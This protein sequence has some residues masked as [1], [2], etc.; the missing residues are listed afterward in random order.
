MGK[1]VEFPGRRRAPAD[2][3]DAAGNIRVAPGR[4]LT[5]GQ[6]SVTPDQAAIGAG[7]GW[8][9]EADSGHD[10][11]VVITRPPPRTLRGALD[12]TGVSRDP[13]YPEVV[14]VTLTRPLTDAEL[15]FF[16]DVCR[17]GAL[18]TEAQRLGGPVNL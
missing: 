16:H 10:G 2:I 6:A 5:C 12:C 7:Y 13:E 4:I 17:E 9:V 11:R 1:V 18:L 15:A 8:A 3:F 14:C